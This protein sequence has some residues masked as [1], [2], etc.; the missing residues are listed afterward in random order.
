MRN[1]I[2]LVGLV[3]F[4]RFV[5]FFIIPILASLFPE[6]LEAREV[7]GQ[8]QQ[9]F[10]EAVQVWLDGED[11]DALERLSQLSKDGNTA[12]QILLANIASRANMHVHVTSD[13]P[14]KER[15]ALWRIPKGLSGKSWLSEAQKNAPLAAA[16]VQ[17]ARIGEKA[18][19]IVALIEYGEPAAALLAAQSM[20][21]SG[22]ATELVEVLQGLDD[23]LP[24]EA[25]VLLLWALG[26]S[27]DVDSGAFTGSA[28]AATLVLGEPALLKSRLA[29]S[30]ESPRALVENDSL[31]GKVAR[32]SNDVK[33]WTPIKNF[34]EKNCPDTQQECIAVGANAWTLAGPFAMRSPAQSLISNDTYW[35]SAR[36]EADLARQIRDVEEWGN[37]SAYTQLNACFFESMHAAQTTHG[38]A[39]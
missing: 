3:A 36:S 4:K 35:S 8:N 34:C 23:K 25:S 13:M 2:Y 30:A 37:W 32:V 28:R 31:L 10:Q 18:P 26:Q 14:R 5:I 22:K 17:A 6:R 7:E 9:A 12:A 38:H 27:Q 11:L 29:W 21:H 1:D 20:L 19:A 39:K 24:E 33:S 16:M 15:I